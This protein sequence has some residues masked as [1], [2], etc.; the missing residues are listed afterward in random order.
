MKNVLALFIFVMFTSMELHAQASLSAPVSTSL[1]CAGQVYTYNVVPANGKTICSV[2][3][4]VTGNYDLD[5]N[6]NLTTNNLKLKWRGDNTTTVSVSVSAKY[7]D[8]SP[9]CGT[10]NNIFTASRTNVIRTVHGRTLSG[11]TVNPANSPFCFSLPAGPVVLKL[12]VNQLQISYTTGGSLPPPDYADGYEWDLPTGWIR[13]GG[14][15]GTQT[16]TL[17]EI[18]IVPNDVST[19]CA[20]TGNVNVRAVTNYLFCSAYPRTKSIAVAIPASRTPALA[21]SPPAGFTAAQ[22]GLTANLVFTATSVPCATQY[23]WILPDGN[24]TQVSQSGASVTVKPSGT[25]GGTLTA[26][27]NTGVCKIDVS[28]NI[29]F[30]PNTPTPTISLS[31]T[32]AGAYEFCNNESY[33]M[34]AVLPAGYPTNFGFD[35]YYLKNVGTTNAVTFNGTNATQASPL[36][37]ATNSATIAVPGGAFGKGWIA[38]RLNNLG[39]CQSLYRTQER[40]I[41][42]YSNTEFYFSGPNS[43]CPNTAVDFVASVIGSGVTGYDW[44]RPAGWSASG[45]NTPYWS[46]SLPS[47]FTSAQITLKLQ[48]RCGWTNTPYVLNISK[49]GSCGA[50]I[51]MAPNPAGDKL[52]VS[53]LEVGTEVFIQLLDKNGTKV[54]EGSTK[55][56]ELTID[57]SKIPSGIY[58]LVLTQG[59]STDT[60]RIIIN[61]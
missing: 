58:Y 21:I 11:A 19:T 4:T 34:T 24:W 28:F 25:S 45:Q 3:W 18:Y 14:G 16:T 48:N 50:R 61:H 59:G 13:Q 22:C 6:S 46:V 7:A 42:P 12:S 32:P 1:L 55:E 8:S 49:S 31:P 56:G 52:V 26:R 47:N 30:N 20:P 33:T 37:T 15:G 51:A 9:D 40:K 35:W 2:T 44:T 10:T 39:S 54:Y 36:H 5:G 27:I 57:V 43:Y 29:P 17:P 23:E 60:E 41:G 38:V 53:E